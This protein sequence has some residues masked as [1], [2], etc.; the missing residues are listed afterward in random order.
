MQLTRQLDPSPGI[1]IEE[2]EIEKI[3]DREE[4]PRSSGF[5]EVAG[6]SE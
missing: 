2:S 6:L 1:S 3:F 5:K 4:K